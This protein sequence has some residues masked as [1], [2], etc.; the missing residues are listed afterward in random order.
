MLLLDLI[1]SCID[2][3]ELH[4]NPNTWNVMSSSPKVQAASK[5][6]VVIDGSVL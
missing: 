4:L 2:K 3:P 5:Q 6:C 1:M